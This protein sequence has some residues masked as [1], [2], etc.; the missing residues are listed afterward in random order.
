M[1]DQTTPP[2]AP[3]LRPA[4]AAPPPASG[5]KPKLNLGPGVGI[6]VQQD[7]AAP[8]RKLPPVKILVI[9]I[10]AL[11]VIVGI[12]SFFTRAKPQGAGSVDNVAA[13]EIPGQNA[14]LVALTVTLR[15]TGEKTLWIHTLHGKLKT[16]SGEYSD[17][18]ASAVDLERYFQAFPALRQNSTHALMPETKL[19]PGE[20]IRGTMVVSFP[21]KQ[22]EFDKR[23]S[24]SAVIQ[25]YDQPVPVVLA[26]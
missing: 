22:E 6:S 9:A 1:P 5:E 8:E 10:A 19:L 16:A 3:P 7:M 15:N 14:M 24:I 11:A 2:G 18:A 23:Q 20:S 21:V 12:L 26:K 17:D 13:V 4:P 25:P